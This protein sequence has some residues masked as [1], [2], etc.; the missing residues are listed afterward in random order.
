MYCLPLLFSFVVLASALRSP[1]V[2]ITL[3]GEYSNHGDPHLLCSIGNWTSIA[4][5]VLINYLAH[6]TTVKSYP[7]DSKINSGIAVVFAL[8]FPSSGV[9]RAVN[10][11][12]RRSRLINGDELTKVARAGGKS[13]FSCRPVLNFCGS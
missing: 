6:C 3:T 1:I 4:L 11:I 8:F 7:G 10:A 12:I 13:L 9:V 5:F 2:N